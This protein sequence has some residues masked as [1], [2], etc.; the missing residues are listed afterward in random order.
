MQKEN[1]LASSVASLP[2]AERRKLLNKLSQKEAMALLYD[3][4][5]WARPNQLIPPG[6]WFLWLLLTGRGFGKTR[7]G[8]ENVCIFAKQGYTPIALV[9]QTK[10]DVRDTMIEVGDSSILRISPPWFKPEYEPSKRRLTWPNGVI[11]IIY[12]GDEPDQLRGPQHAKAW[13]D[14]LSKFR[15]PEDTWDNLEFG[16]RVG[17]KP[18]VIVSTTPRPIPIIKALVKDPSA[19]VTRGTSYENQANLSPSF[20]GRILGRYEGTRLGRQELRGEILEDNPDAL[21]RR[22][23]IDELRVRQNPPCSRVVVGVDPEAT[24]GENSAETGIVVAGSAMQDGKLQGYVLDDLSIRASP[25]GWASA[26]IT[27]YYKHKADLVIAEDNNG[28][29]MV[30]YTIR[31]VDSKVPV[32]RIH[33]SRGK[34]TRAEPISALYEQQ[35]IHHVGFFSDLEDQM[36]EWVPGDKSP[37]R[38]DAL[39]WSLTELFNAGEPATVDVPK[40]TRRPEFSGIRGRQF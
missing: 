38:L 20:I 11:G 26:V 16:M 17:D 12:S 39:V 1:S 35:K 13:V 9:G 22:Q 34:Y 31:S 19:V 36:C 4:E 10:A 33:A 7:T 27:A 6:D 29:E 21:W 37:D 15:Y 40:I 2:E 8:A 32:K 24:S 14:E 23:A 30:E 28:G 3:W 18:Q 5:F 25:N